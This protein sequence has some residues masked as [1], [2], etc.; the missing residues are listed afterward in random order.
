ML[1]NNKIIRSNKIIY[2]YS[3]IYFLFCPV[4]S[5]VLALLGH[6]CRHHPLQLVDRSKKILALF[7]ST[8]KTEMTSKLR[9]P[10]LSVIAGALEGLCSLLYNFTQSADEDQEQ[11]KTPNLGLFQRGHFGMNHDQLGLNFIVTRVKHARFWVHV[12][13]SFISNHMTSYDSKM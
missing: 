5:N 6:L 1:R 4:K 2:N 7:T 3:A 13:S 9:K 11:V 8:L 12:I 10:D